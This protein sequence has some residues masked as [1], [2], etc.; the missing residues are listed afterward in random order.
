MIPQNLKQNY[1]L[2][3]QI[4]SKLYAPKIST[5]R[6]AIHSSLAYIWKVE[7]RKGSLTDEWIHFVE[8][9]YSR[10][11]FAHKKEWNIGTYYNMEEMLK[12]YGTW[13]MPD[14][15]SYIMHYSIYMKF[16]E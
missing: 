16:Q 11:L 2:I 5:Q 12:Y 15:K 13:K 3:L 10:V 4:H 6:S 8:Y 7:T 14:T 1:R 9:A